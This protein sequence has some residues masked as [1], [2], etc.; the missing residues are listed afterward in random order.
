MS[1]ESY[2]VSLEWSKKLKEAGWKKET[3]YY[4]V[5]ELPNKIHEKGKVALESAPKEGELI[6]EYFMGTKAMFHS[7]SAPLATEILEELPFRLRRED[8]DY[9]LWI[10]KMKHGGYRVQ[11]SDNS[12][13][14]A[15]PI[16]K[17][18]SLSC[19]LAAMWIY[20]QKEPHE[21]R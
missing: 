10:T 16:F 20:L 14:G 8:D 1:I 11:Y 18:D 13:L 9:W 17:D 19:S 3:I 4:W 7:F 12:H 2:V 5:Q 21:K 6:I 15:F